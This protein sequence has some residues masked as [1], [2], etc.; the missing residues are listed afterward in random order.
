MASA[1][2]HKP[3][4]RT[5]ALSLVFFLVISIAV[6]IKFF[7]KLSLLVEENNLTNVYVGGV[8]VL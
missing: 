1:V 3:K 4:P 6:F 8:I 5:S 2:P 7:L